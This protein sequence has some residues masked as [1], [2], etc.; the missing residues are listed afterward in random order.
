MDN[1]EDLNRAIDA[2]CERINVGRTIGMYGID[3]ALEGVRHFEAELE[4]LFSTNGEVLTS[5]AQF[6]DTT[7]FCW[8]PT[9]GKHKAWVDAH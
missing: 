9:K 2:I 6:N 3:I 4:E 1:R 8:G 7:I 5:E